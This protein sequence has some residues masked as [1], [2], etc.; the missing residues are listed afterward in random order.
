MDTVGQILSAVASL[1]Y[2]VC[3]ILLIVKMF[4]HGQ[5]VLAIVCLVCCGP[6][7]L[8]GFVYGWMKSGEWGIRNMMIVWTICF[9]LSIVGGALSPSTFSQF[10]GK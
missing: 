1:G 5:V 8:I 10:T 3:F 6:G 7:T 2:L 4:Q 9:I